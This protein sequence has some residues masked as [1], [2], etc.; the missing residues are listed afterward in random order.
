AAFKA[1]VNGK[2]VAVLVPT[3]I[4]AQQHYMTFKD[5]LGRYPISTGAI[6][7]FRS[8]AEQKDLLKNL[9]EGKLDIIIGTHRLLSQ[10]VK[11]KDLGLLVI[12]EEQRFGV[13]AKEKLRQMRANIDTLTLTATPIPRTLNFSLMGARDLSI[14]ETPP[15][16]RIPIQTEVL[17]WNESV[18]KDAI[19]KE[20]SRKGQVFFVNDRVESIDKLAS[21]LKMMLPHVRFGVVHG[22]MTGSAIESAM[23]KYVE[24]KYDV[25]IATKKVESGLDIPNAN[26]MIINNSHKFGLAELYQLRG[27]V[28][29]SNIQAFC[30]LLIP[31]VKS[32]NRKALL[33]LQAIEEFT[34]L[35]MGY[36][37]AM[38]DLEIRGA[39]NMLGPEQ[40][41]FINEMGFEL[42]H[43]ILDEAVEELRTREFS[44][45]FMDI[46]IKP[47]PVENEDIAIELDTDAML[48]AD[49][50]RSDT[51]RFHFYKKLYKLRTPVELQGQIDELRDRFGKLPPQ[52]QELMYAVK[53]RIA[54][55][56]TGIQKVILKKNMLIVEFPMKSNAEY[57]DRVFPIILEF[58]DE[59]EEVKIGESK[60]KLTITLPIPGRDAAIEVLWR[61]NRYI[62]SAFE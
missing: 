18:I 41:G 55:L 57:Y 27:R 3:T 2:Q 50:V 42:Y 13:G 14:I 48:P 9:G 11:F 24:G 15:R 45:L 30:Y 51:E 46:V 53:V 34:D 20:I 61:M 31:P 52:A 12:D 6:S 49:Y 62:N 10:D 19:E 8:A 36:Q 4:L 39:G 23:E 58:I 59:L 21:N 60:G 16:N 32:L 40:S 25:I 28:G 44:D 7:R 35:G 56:A 5:R 26:T 17:I 22:Q 38:R 1:A 43:K 47:L 54:A 37:L 29:R 33:R